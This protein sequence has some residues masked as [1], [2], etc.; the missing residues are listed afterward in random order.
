MTDRLSH[1]KALLAWQAVNRQSNRTGWYEV[2]NA[3][4]RAVVD[5]YDEIGFMGVTASQFV[6]DLRAIKASTIEL[7]VN[8]PGGSIVDGLAIYNALRD[9][10]ARVDTVVDGIAASAASWV[11]LAGDSVTMNRHS[12]VMIHD[13]MGLTLGSAS[14]HREAADLLD[15]LSDNIAA[16]YASR[17]GGTAAQ[18]RAAMTAE[19]WYSAAEAV[20]AGLATQMVSDPTPTNVRIA[21]TRNRLIRARAR[22]HLAK[23]C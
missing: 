7:R 6:K 5:L 21:N 17:A 16:I 20:A 3:A 18:W 1:P 15:R 22:V 19:T 8:S 2:S 14:D 4:D 12:Q 9:H 13:G 10:P 11:M 23:E